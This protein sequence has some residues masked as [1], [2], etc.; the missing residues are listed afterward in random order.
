MI[1]VGQ[2][3][4]PISSIC[5]LEEGTDNLWYVHFNNGETIYVNR[6]IAEE[7]KLKMERDMQD[8]KIKILKIWKT[9]TW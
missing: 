5:F 6:Y 4:F 1:N 2:F 3:F 8:N 7:I 9:K